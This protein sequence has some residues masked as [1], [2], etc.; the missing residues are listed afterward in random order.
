MSWDAFV[1]GRV[2]CCGL[3][4]LIDRQVSFRAPV[5]PWHTTNSS[6]MRSLLLRYD[7]RVI[8]QTSCIYK[9]HVVNYVNIMLML[10]PSPNPAFSKLTI[11]ICYIPTAH[12]FPSK[13][14]SSQPMLLT[15]TQWQPTSRIWINL[16]SALRNEVDIISQV[17]RHLTT[18]WLM[19]QTGKF[20]LHS[21]FLPLLDCI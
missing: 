20:V 10:M 9:K 19:H 12:W 5:N 16:P 15:D 7:C 4:N 14:L 1:T 8:R 21:V 13:Q 18:Q 3:H 2:N 6:F 11:H 17:G